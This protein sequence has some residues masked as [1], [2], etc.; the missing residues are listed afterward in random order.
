[1]MGSFRFGLPMRVQPLEFRRIFHAV[2]MVFVLS[3]ILFEVLDLD[4][5]RLPTAMVPVEQ[6]AIAAE[7]PALVEPGH[8]PDRA[9]SWDESIVI[10]NGLHAVALP[11]GFQ[12]PLFSRLDSART[13]RYRVGLPRDAIIDPH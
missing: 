2:C 10:D 5:S 13:H 1:M 12:I 9:R 8:R 6:A 4:G 3:Y 11:D 7:P